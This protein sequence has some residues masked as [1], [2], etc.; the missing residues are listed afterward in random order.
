MIRNTRQRAAILEAI[1]TTGRPLTALEIFDIGKSMVPNLG[2]RTVYR[3][4]R[5]LTESEAIVCVDYPGQPSRYEVVTNQEHCVHFI[6]RSCDRLFHLNVK[7]PDMDLDVPPGF[8]VMGEEI[9]L[10][11]TCLDC[12]RPSSSNS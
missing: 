11:G 2:L 9:I 6:C 1:E 3:N 5:E 8:Q 4:L 12:A 10:Y 7:T